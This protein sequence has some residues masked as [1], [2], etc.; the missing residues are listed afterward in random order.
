MSISFDTTGL[1]QRDANTWIDPPTP[2]TLL[3]EQFGVVPDLPA[4]L[5][6]LATLRARLAEIHARNGC[7]VEAFVIGVDSQPALLRIEKMP[8]PNQDHGLVFIASIV[9]PKADRSIRLMRI[10][11][12]SGTTGI[13]EAVLMTKIGFQ[14]MFP[15]H[16]YAPGVKGA[17][18]Y[19]LADDI[20]YDPEFPDH[21]LT[22]ARRWVA[23]I[24]PTMRLAPDFAGLPP[25]HR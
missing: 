6:D 11:P 3:L 23:R 9:I 15:P 8:L 1:Q 25:F 14:S 20:Q 18:P 4:P 5:E 19:N 16:P 7:L 24:V 21:P 22:R 12:E 13:R 17:L 2:D 10:C